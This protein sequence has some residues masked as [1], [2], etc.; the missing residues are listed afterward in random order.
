MSGEGETP[1]ADS[2]RRGR[3]PILAQWLV[4]AGVVVAF[5]AVMAAIQLPSL[6]NSIDRKKQIHTMS[7]L[8]EISAA[9][10]SYAADMNAYPVTEDFEELCGVLEPKYAATLR[11]VDGWQHSF[12]IRAYGTGYV[13]G[14][15]GKDGAGKLLIVGDG[16]GTTRYEDA[17]LMADG[18][19]IQWPEGTHQRPSGSSNNESTEPEPSQ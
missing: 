8:R 9:I 16:G 14:S 2:S 7:D 17:I 13:L 19:F 15:G 5:I 11:R 12:A 1:A 3:G 10:E 4:G 6:R 18:E